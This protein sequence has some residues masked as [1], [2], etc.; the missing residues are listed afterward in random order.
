[1]KRSKQA[2]DSCGNSGPRNH[3]F[4]VNVI[5]RVN[6]MSAWAFGG[7]KKLDIAAHSGHIVHVCDI[8]IVCGIWLGCPGLRGYAQVVVAGRSGA[9]LTPVWG[10]T[11]TI[12]DRPESKKP[13]K[14]KSRR[15][16]SRNILHGRLEE[17]T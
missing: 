12:T 17:D 10:R 4:S 7:Y 2:E 14:T 11:H 15:V 3:P 8:C 6:K 5:N 1:M 13:L 16:D 9:V